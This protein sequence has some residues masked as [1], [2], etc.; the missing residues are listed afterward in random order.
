[1]IANKNYNTKFISYLNKYKYI[2]NKIQSKYKTGFKKH[3][4]YIHVGYQ[5]ILN[6]QYCIQI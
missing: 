5:I 3:L 4:I 2:I 1:M 6:K